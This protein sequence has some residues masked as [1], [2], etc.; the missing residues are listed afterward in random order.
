M[1]KQRPDRMH[2][3]L[4]E[5]KF[6]LKTISLLEMKLKDFLFILTVEIKGHK[7]GGGIL[8]TLLKV[9]MW[10]FFSQFA[11]SRLVRM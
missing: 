6:P 3:T 10:K 7:R 1:E 9:R 2:L 11:T 4:I 5:C 8:S